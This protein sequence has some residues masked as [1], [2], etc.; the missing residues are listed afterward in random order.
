MKRLVAAMIVLAACASGTATADGPRPPQTS[1]Q[2]IT[3][4]TE[5]N[6]PESSG[7]IWT[8]VL[9]ID[10]RRCI[11]TVEHYYYKGSGVATDCEDRGVR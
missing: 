6:D 7:T 3:D 9:I 2:E 8:R 4:W 11:V 5:L 1:V 10:G